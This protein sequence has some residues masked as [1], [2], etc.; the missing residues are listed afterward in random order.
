MALLA[1]MVSIGQ[2]GN[3][4]AITKD[5]VTI[6]FV[7]NID[8]MFAGF[9]PDDV[10]TNAKKLNSSK[11]L[12]MGKDYNTYKLIWKRFKRTWKRTEDEFADEVRVDTQAYSRELANLL[13]NF[14]CGLVIN[15][16][17]IVYSYFAPF[18][19]III[20]F[21]GYYSQI[22]REQAKKGI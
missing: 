10:K 18:M 17:V 16:Q 1:L 7:L 5:Y 13:V 15:F 9:L 3:L 21:I 11:V 12:K 19:S 14:W 4:G 6:A 20:Q 22:K 2:E 8:N